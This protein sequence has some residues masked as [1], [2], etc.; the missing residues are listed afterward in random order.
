MQIFIKTLTGKMITIEV[1]MDDTIAALKQK[2]F[3]KEDILTKNK[4]S[5]FV[6]RK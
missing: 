6:V 4:D 2:V 3:E 5:F 1:S